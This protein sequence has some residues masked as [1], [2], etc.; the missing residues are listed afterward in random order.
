VSD[1]SETHPINLRKVKIPISNGAVIGG[2]TD[3]E[4]TESG[5]LKAEGKNC[6]Y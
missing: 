2:V 3:E 5:K 4:K 1:E 6:C